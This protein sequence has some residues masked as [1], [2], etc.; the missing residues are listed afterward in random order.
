VIRETYDS[1]LRI[2]RSA[3]E[4]MGIPRDRA[5]MMVDDFNQVD[6][7]AMLAVADAFDP[8][9]P[10]MENHAYIARVRAAR[11]LGR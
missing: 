2:G 8:T 7:Q 6:Q 1:S 11:T 3:L 10:V 5:Q 9:V 4:A